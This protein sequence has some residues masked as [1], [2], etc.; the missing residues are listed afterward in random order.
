MQLGAAMVLICAAQA[1]SGFVPGGLALSERAGSPGW[2]RAS[3]HGCGVARMRNLRGGCAAGAPPPGVRSAAMIFDGLFGKASSKETPGKFVRHGSLENAG[4]AFGPRG[5]VCAGLGEEEL[6]VLAERVEQVLRGPDGQAGNIPITVLG[7]EDMND[8][9]TLADVLAQMD[10][11]DSVLPEEPL[12]LKMPLILLSVRIGCVCK[13]GGVW[14]YSRHDLLCSRA[15]RWS[16]DTWR[17]EWVAYM[18]RVCEE[19]IG[20]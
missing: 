5:I 7:R 13:G 9:T 14:I 10:E 3:M 19:M 8:R 2:A 15:T 20:S 11:R 17:R 1:C 4:A 12:Q 6:E 18:L 16:T